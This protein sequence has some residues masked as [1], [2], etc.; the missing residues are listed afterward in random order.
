MAPRPKRTFETVMKKASKPEKRNEKGEICTWNRFS[1]DANRLQIFVANGMCE[2]KKPAEV[3]EM[4][5]QFKK[6][7]SQCFSS[8]LSNMRKTH[9][10][11]IYDRA[12]AISK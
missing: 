2:G 8:A 4:F 10:K 5:P 9:N 6:Y 7:S 12:A 1:E 11:Q 3:Q